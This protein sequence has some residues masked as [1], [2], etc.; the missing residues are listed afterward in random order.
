MRA[1]AR[2]TRTRYCAR[3]VLCWRALPLVSTLR[4]TGS[5]ADRSALFVGFIATMAE[6]DFPR[7]CIIGS[8]S[9]PSRCGPPASSGDGQ[10]RDIPGSDTILSRVMWPSTPAGRQRL[11]KRRCSCCV[12]P[13]RRSPPLRYAHFVAQSHTPR[14]RCVRFVAAVAVSSRNTRFQAA[15]YGPTW[16]G[17]S[18]PDRASLLAPTSIRATSDR[19]MG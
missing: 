3:C 5:A 18:P 9:S 16:A 1:S 12:R 7:P 15:R 2:V 8:G 10:T 14:N 6:S 17:L 4:S 13:W 19:R 11:A